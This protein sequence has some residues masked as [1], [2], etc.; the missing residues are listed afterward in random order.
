MRTMW[1]MVTVVLGAATVAMGQGK[2]F[3]LQ[4]E[5]E[6]VYAP[7]QP[8]RE[9]QGV[10]EGGVNVNLSAMFMT[11]YVY[12]GIDRSGSG[13]AEDAPNLS[14]DSRLAWDLGR[15]PH[16]FVGVFVNVY[17]SDPASRFQEVRPYFGFDWNM[18]PLLF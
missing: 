15:R 16:P 2:P 12:R 9:D 3:S 4:E 11:D 5:P 10:N 14:I 1:W 18:R 8:A 13:G 17:D 7:P 6:S